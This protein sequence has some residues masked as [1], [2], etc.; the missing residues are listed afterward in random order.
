MLVILVF[1]EDLTQKHVKPERL[2]NVKGK[3]V[4]TLDFSKTAFARSGP[5]DVM[6]SV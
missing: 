5:N 6:P 2:I 1:R 4:G 3:N